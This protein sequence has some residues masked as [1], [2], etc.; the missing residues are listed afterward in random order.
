MFKSQR[1]L[2]EQR[3]LKSLEESKEITGHPKLNPNSEQ[4]CQKIQ[5]EYFR[6]L[7]TSCEEGSGVEH[8]K[9]ASAGNRDG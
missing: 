4:I 7:A 3:A 1:K 5:E 6:Q 9:N 2:E 8:S